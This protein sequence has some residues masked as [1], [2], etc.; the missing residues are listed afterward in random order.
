MA[1][2]LNTEFDSRIVRVSIGAAGVTRPSLAPD[3]LERV[4]CLHCGTPGGYVTAELPP[5]LWHDPGVIYVCPE[6]D[7]KFGRL[8][9]HAISF[10]HRR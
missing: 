1:Q 10:E 7:A 8:P 4:Y 3:G 5:A 9:A 2:A 6:C